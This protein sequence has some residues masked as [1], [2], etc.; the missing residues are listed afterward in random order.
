MTN[1]STRRRK[2]RRSSTDWADELVVQHSLRFRKV[3]NRY[4]LRVTEAYEGD[5]AAAAADDGATVAARVAAWERAQGLPVTDWVALG[6]AE[7]R[8]Q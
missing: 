5:I 1:E 8:G 7:G 4:T 6:E 3:S 2:L